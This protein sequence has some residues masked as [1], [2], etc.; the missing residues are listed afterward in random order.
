MEQKIS[1]LIRLIGEEVSIFET[2]VDLLNRQQEALV[3][4]N[5][6]MLASVTQEQE[7]LAVKT[8][9]VEKRRTDLIKALSHEIN[10]DS[11]DMNITE[12]TK[13]AAEPELNQLRELQGTLIGL[14]DQIAT[15]K[16]RNDFLIK[17]SME[18]INNTL[19]YLSAANNREVTYGA[20]KNKRAN[21][22]H[23][24]V[25]DRRI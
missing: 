18:Y 11:A 19:T 23:L 24:A 21:A 20:D 7:Q 2:F 14:H 25:V 3:T 1:Q 9:L 8:A 5:M 16:A 15:I 17:K 12:L 13:L 10:R 6:E 4:N 22:G